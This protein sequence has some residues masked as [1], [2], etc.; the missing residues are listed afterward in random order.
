M[1]ESLFNTTLFALAVCLGTVACAGST[2]ATDPQA[3][4][5]S[6][7]AGSTSTD[8][9]ESTATS[10]AT[11][12]AE[13]TETASS[14]GSQNANTAPNTAPGTVGLPASSASAWNTGQSDGQPGKADRGIADYQRIIGENREKFRSCYDAS[15]A[16]QKG[17]KGRVT[18]MW[19]LDPAGAVKDGASIEQASSDF[20]CE[21]LETCLVTTLKTLTFPPSTR[22]MNSSVRYPF[23]FQ[24]V[25]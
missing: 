18:L 1:R 8:P 3:P 19:V 22:G 21:T 10:T 25:K 7:A 17:N 2:T 4:S 6:T 23:D 9:S 16:K 13:A 12:A 5:E 20:Y 11:P 14:D 24:L 15:P